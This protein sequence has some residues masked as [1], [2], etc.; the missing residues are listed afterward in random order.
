MNFIIELYFGAFCGI[1]FDKN[2]IKEKAF[3]RFIN[4]NN[5]FIFLIKLEIKIFL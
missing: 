3:C 1:K 2:N 5:L 4:K